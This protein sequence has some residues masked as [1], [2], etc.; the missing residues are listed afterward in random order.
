MLYILLKQS[1]SGYLGQ[2]AINHGLEVEAD[3]VDMCKIFCANYLAQRP[4]HIKRKHEANSTQELD[5]TEEDD[6]SSRSSSPRSL[7]DDRYTEN[8]IDNNEIGISELLKDVSVCQ[9]V[10]G[11]VFT[12]DTAHNMKYDRCVFCI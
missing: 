10:V 5:E 6:S 9:P 8:H 3:V 1:K 4:L 11:N 2:D 7:L 12:M